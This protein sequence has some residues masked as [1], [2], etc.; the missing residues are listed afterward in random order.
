M[1][2]HQT[3]EEQ[4]E[5]E[6]GVFVEKQTNKKAIHGKFNYVRLYDRNKHRIS[7]PCKTETELLEQRK[8][9]KEQKF[10]FWNDLVRPF[11][12]FRTGKMKEY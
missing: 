12:D 11:V 3:W 8:N 7:I 1:K 6:K 9:H 10:F 5:I 4:K 2:N